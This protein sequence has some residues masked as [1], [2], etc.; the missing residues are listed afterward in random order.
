M[1]ANVEEPKCRQTAVYL[2]A[3][4][5]KV[6]DVGLVPIQKAAVAISNLFNV[7]LHQWAVD[8]RSLIISKGSQ[9]AQCL[10][11][12]SSRNRRLQST[13]FKAVVKSSGYGSMTAA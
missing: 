9:K 10:V 1:L 3:P 11:F 8:Q 7:L 6:R 12:G 13:G 2:E 4:T 5:G